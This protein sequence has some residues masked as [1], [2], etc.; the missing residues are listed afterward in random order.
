MQINR[1][2]F[3]KK[4]DELWEL[5]ASIGYAVLVALS[6]WVGYHLGKFQRPKV[7][8]IG[9]IRKATNAPQIVFYAIV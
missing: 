2:S 5:G 4:I 1:E 8:K 9:I 3:N 6:F 7:P